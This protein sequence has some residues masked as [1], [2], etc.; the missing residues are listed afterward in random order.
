RR[1]AARRRA[2]SDGCAGA[3]ARAPGGAHRGGARARPARE[4]GVRFAPPAVSFVPAP[5]RS[6]LAAIGAGLPRA[7]WILWA[8]T[9]VNR[10]GTFVVPFM[11]VYLTQARGFSPAAAGAVASLYGAGSAVASALGGYL[12]DHVRRRATKVGALAL[13]GLGIIGLGFARDP[14][15]IAPACFFVAVMG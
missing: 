15:V 4:R 8:G 9:F 10:A 13:G 7:Y 11:A 14:V 5:L 1:V 3:A 12:A 2:P 6:R